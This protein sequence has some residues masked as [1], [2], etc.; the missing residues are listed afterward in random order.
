MNTPRLP[1]IVSSQAMAKR[2][3]FGLPCP[4]SES[5]DA[6]D[7]PDERRSE[8]QQAA[9]PIE[10]EA[11]AQRWQLGAEGRAANRERAGGKRGR[12]SERRDRSR[13]TA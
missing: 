2:S 8:E 7:E 1:A 10:P 3:A 11:H 4:S 12:R 9:G 5:K 6:D 13:Q